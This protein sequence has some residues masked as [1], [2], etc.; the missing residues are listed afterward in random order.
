MNLNFNSM[1]FVYSMSMGILLSLSSNNWLMIWIGLEISLMSIMPL[2]AVKNPASSE[3]CLKYFIIQSISSSLMMLG[4]L[5]MTTNSNYNYLLIMSLSIMIKV[6]AAPFHIWMLQIIEAMNWMMM[7]LMLSVIKIAPVNMLSYMSVK[8]NLMSIM[9]LMVGSLMGLLQ[10]SIRKILVYSSIF[11]LGFLIPSISM[12]SVWMTYFFI[13]MISLFMIIL[14]L[15]EM[16]ATYIN[17]ITLNEKNTL[18]KVN[19]FMI[20]ISM[21][22]MPPMLGFL[23]KLMVIEL[24]T[25]M[26]ELIITLLMISSSIVV[27]FFYMRLSFLSSLFSSIMI[28]TQVFKTLKISFWMFMVN[29]LLTPLTFTLKCLN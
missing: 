17:Q 21:G 14:P 26:Q 22:G 12:N 19:I 1:L 28:K 10:N 16:N 2:M 13:Y 4:M 23:G 20:M 6:G 18:S 7:F 24:M 29:L 5:L 15:N 27:M 25:N 3:S 8:L 11:N 9:C